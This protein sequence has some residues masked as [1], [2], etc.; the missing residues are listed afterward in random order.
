[1]PEL[2]VAGGVGLG[3][4]TAV[5]DEEGAN[6][7][8]VLTEVVAR[9]RR[10]VGE[11]QGSLPVVPRRRELPDALVVGL[12]LQEARQ[13]GG[14]GGTGICACLVPVQPEGP[15]G[16]RIRT[17]LLDGRAGGGVVLVGIS[18][19]YVEDRLRLF[20]VRPAGRISS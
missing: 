10:G 2:R 15:H 13:G 14:D 3:E 20:P 8:V 4:E 19:R 17:G 9:A 12:E 16:L 11:E 5:L 6:C 18:R 1:R 7:L